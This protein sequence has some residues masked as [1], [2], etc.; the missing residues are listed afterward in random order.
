[1]DATLCTKIV[2]PSPCLLPAI[3]QDNLIFEKV[4]QCTVLH[5]V[6]MT[7]I[8]NKLL[9][10]SQQ[11]KTSLYIRITVHTRHVMP[12]LLTGNYSI[13][14]SFDISTNDFQ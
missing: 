8:D 13:G 3:K 10:L 2:P 1:M 9:L 14:H 11:R 7:L 4:L 6:L 5:R 12:I